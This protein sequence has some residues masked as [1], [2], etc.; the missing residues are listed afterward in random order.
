MTNEEARKLVNLKHSLVLMGMLRF[1][2]VNQFIEQ[3]HSIMSRALNME[4]L[5][6]NNFNKL[7]KQ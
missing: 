7:S 5:I 1:K 3:Y 4:D 2:P 6:S